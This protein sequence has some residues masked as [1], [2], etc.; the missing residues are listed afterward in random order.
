M[1]HIRH[2]QPI[3]KF[4]SASDIDLSRS[5][6]PL[7]LLTTDGNSC[8][9]DYSC[10]LYYNDQSTSDAISDT[11]QTYFNN[12][13]E[14]SHS[15]ESF[16]NHSDISPDEADS[17][18]NE[19][20]DDII[21]STANSSSK[22]INAATHRFQVLLHDLMMKH[23]TSL[24][25]FDDICSLVND[26]TSSHEFSSTSR[27]QTRKAFLCSIEHGHN[28]YG[29]QPTN[30]NVRLHDNSR[31]TV[32]IFNIKEMIISLLTDKSLMRESN[33]AEGYNVLMGAVDED[34][35]SNSKYGKIHTGDA[36]LPARN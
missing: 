1:K 7:L 18:D 9:I 10:N 24:Q 12:E 35:P 33:F 13:C 11:N 19:V 27:M 16:I 31:V 8:N 15:N 32:P 23:R 6:N 4:S 22:V 26:Y 2:C 29:L 30:M 34:H 25:L 5:L 17:D 28:G 36:W 14:R 20:I 21:G 3:S